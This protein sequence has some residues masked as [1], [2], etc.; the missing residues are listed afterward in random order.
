MLHM[1]DVT[2]TALRP[3]TLPSDKTPVFSP[4][5]R[6]PEHSA[7]LGPDGAAIRYERAF[8]DLAP[9]FRVGMSAEKFLNTFLQ[10]DNGAY[11]RT[12]I[13]VH[14]VESALVTQ[15]SIGARRPVLEHIDANLTL[16]PDQN[17][18]EDDKGT[19]RK[20]KLTTPPED[21]FVSPF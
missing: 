2:D 20:S 17:N 15:V 12:N 16:E 3:S 14:E 11:A 6:Q 10:S 21:A 5:V 9:Y 1:E 19:E 18:E 8:L 4:P 7:L 13:C